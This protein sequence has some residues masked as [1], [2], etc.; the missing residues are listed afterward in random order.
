MR[1]SPILHAHRARVRVELTPRR[2]E[3]VAQRDVDVSVRAVDAGVVAH[4]E[5]PPG[6][7]DHDRRVEPT[8]VL[9][10]PMR[11]LDRDRAS[12]DAIEAPLQPG[13][14]SL[15]VRIDARDST[16]AAVVDVCGDRHIRAKCTRGARSRRA[17]PTLIART[18]GTRVALALGMRSRARR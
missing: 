2:A 7:L 9:L 14:A 17:R 5:R 10:V 3:R 18:T 13:D 16:E 12:V 1:L 11:E 15:D 8:P 4:R 6:H